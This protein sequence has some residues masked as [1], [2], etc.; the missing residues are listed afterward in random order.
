MKRA[1]FALIFAFVNATSLL[2]QEDEGEPPSNTNPD[3]GGIVIEP[4]HGDIAA[5]QEITITFPT[6]M[7]PADRIDVADQPM[8][9]V[10]TP[11]VEGT[12]LWKS[13][14][15]G[16]FSVRGVV[17]GA[18]HRFTLLPKLADVADKPIN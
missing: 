12:F 6:A 7:V 4:D 8:P 3:A 14:T 10:T 9:L 15:E 18:H 17:P 2:A 13:Q 11:K 5:G 16:V 1:A